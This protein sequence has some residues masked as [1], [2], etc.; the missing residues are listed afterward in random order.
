MGVKGLSKT[1]IHASELQFK[2]LLQ[3]KKSD[4]F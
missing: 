3:K 2:Q 4:F 1:T